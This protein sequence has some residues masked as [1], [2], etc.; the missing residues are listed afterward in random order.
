MLTRINF[1]KDVIYPI[2]KIEVRGNLCTFFYNLCTIYVQFLV[3]DLSKFRASEVFWS[4][5]IGKGVSSM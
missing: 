1:T 3:K 4:Q 5:H 2:H